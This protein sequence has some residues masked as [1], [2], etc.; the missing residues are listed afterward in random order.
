MDRVRGG[1]K[2]LR[3]DDPARHRLAGSVEH[4]GRRCSRRRR[5]RVG[6]RWQARRCHMGSWGFARFAE[7][8]ERLGLRRHATVWVGAC[9]AGVRCATTRVGMVRATRRSELTALR[10]VKN[11]V[12][13]QIPHLLSV[14][15]NQTNVFLDVGQSN[16]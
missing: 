12:L 9:W 10:A 15:C 14:W 11:G 3:R 5:G 2:E 1:G 4:R 8:A 7:S 6:K 13:Q 16:V